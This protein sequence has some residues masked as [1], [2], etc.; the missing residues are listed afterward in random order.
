MIEKLGLF[1]EYYTLC[2]AA[3]KQ[4]DAACYN[5]SDTEKDHGALKQVKDKVAKNQQYIDADTNKM[6]AINAVFQS[7]ESEFKTYMKEQ[8]ETKN[9]PILK[10]TISNDKPLMT[11]SNMNDL[12]NTVLRYT[13]QLDD[14]FSGKTQ[15]HTF[16]TLAI[17]QIAKDMVKIQTQV[18]KF[19]PAEILQQ[20]LMELNINL[21]NART[22]IHNAQHKLLDQSRTQ[23]G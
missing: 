8:D 17:D 12:T 22:F 2:V 20:C 16:M 3:Q 18:D 14:L 15:D 5:Y 23:K 21:T 4:Y 1:R 13:E 19:Q 7:M 9:I 6:N 10:S 11:L